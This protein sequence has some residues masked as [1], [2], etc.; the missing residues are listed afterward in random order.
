MKKLLMALFLTSLSVS[1]SLTDGLA[2]H[3]PF[4]G[5][6]NDASGNGKHGTTYGVTLT[7]DR[8]GNAN[9]AF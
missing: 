7:T 4:D 9:E 2:T 1:A 3:W 8:L 6:A 5:K